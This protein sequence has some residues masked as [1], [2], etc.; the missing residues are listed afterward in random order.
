MDFKIGTTTFIY[1]NP[2]FIFGVILPLKKFSK[3]NANFNAKFIYLFI[4]Y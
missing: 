4:I 3:L 2:I 1:K